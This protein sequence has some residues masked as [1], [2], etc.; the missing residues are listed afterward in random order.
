MAGYAGHVPCA[1]EQGDTICALLGCSMPLIIR[2]EGENNPY[3][4]IG[5]CYVHG[6]MEEEALD[7]LKTRKVQLETITFC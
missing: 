4:L 1:A 6:M 3:K 7:W 2:W 5:E